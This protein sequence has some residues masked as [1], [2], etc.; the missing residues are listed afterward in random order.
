MKKKN[1]DKKDYTYANL[2]N[3]NLLEATKSAI[4]QASQSST[5]HGFQ[6]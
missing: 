3:V 5:W 6:S 2:S 4:K 1:I